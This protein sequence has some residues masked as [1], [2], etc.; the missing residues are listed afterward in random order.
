[1]FSWEAFA[2]LVTSVLAVGA[3]WHVGRNQLE[4][5]RRQV[6]LTE[7]DLKIQLLEKRTECIVAMREISDAWTANLELPDNK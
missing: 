5:Q 2:T 1:M 3:A 4:I 6:K 7:N